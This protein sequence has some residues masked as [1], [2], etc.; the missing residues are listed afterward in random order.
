[1]GAALREPRFRFFLGGSFLSNVGSWMQTVAEAWLVLQIT[2]SAFYLGLNGFANT[3]PLALFA[4]W[5]GVIADRF[6]R[7]RLLLGTQWLMMCL[8]L[9]LAILVQTHRVQVWQ[10][11][12]LSCMAGLVQAVA[13]PAYQSVLANVVEPDQL[14][15]AIALNSTQFN[16]ART[17]GPLAGAWGLS[18]LGTAGCFYANAA[19]FLAVILALIRIRDL[20]KDRRQPSR[21]GFFEAFTEGF[22][23][24]RSEKTLLWFL[25][26][27]GVTSILGVPMV[28]LL[29]IFAR[30]V[31]HR[32]VEAFGMLV[33]S[34]GA[35]AIVAG[36]GVA[37]LGN[38][39][40]KGRV[41]M[42][43][44][45][46]FVGALLA[47][48]VSRI[49]WLSMV[50]LMAAG[51]SMVGYAS[52]I[53]SIVQSTAPDHMRGRAMSVFVFAFGGCMPVG[54]LM[55]GFLAKHLGAPETLLFQGLALAGFALY[56]QLAHREVLRHP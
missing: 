35:G 10:I 36:L 33:G 13:W 30:D 6:D 38:F 26:I 2:N 50:C 24:M 32:G 21:T 56:V 17:L 46:I 49:F 55:A 31:L 22:R 4:F 54:N 27:M 11:I 9:T 45:W 48:S 34:F 40:H 29:P 41:V 16:L 51:F 47:F 28:T 15:N 20:R 39:Q 1:V 8:A 19:S 18:H 23:F 5:G 37:L 52:L 12:F 25:I 44:L 42:A 43:S 14:T 53:N 3:I 7:R